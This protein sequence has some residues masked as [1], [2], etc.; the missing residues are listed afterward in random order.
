VVEARE[1]ARRA[2]EDA[3]S[4]LLGF[5]WMFERDENGELLDGEPVEINAERL[6]TDISPK[7]RELFARDKKALQTIEQIDKLSAASV[8]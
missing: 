6:W 5:N 1:T 8:A 7:L 3:E 2:T 4:N